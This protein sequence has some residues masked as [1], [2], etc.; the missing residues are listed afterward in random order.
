M[1]E[2]LTLPYS[3]V[4]DGQYQVGG[5]WEGWPL[6]G[7]I[8]QVYAQ[9]SVT[10]SIHSGVDIDGGAEGVAD[11]WFPQDGIARPQYW[12]DY[13][14]WYSVEIEEPDP[15]YG[16]LF[17]CLA[18][19]HPGTL[20]ITSPTRITAGTFA[21]KM[22]NSGK[23]FGAH[24]HFSVSYDMYISGDY[25]RCVDP[26]IFVQRWHQEEE[27]IPE[28]LQGFMLIAE[29]DPKVMQDV[30]FAL[31]NFRGQGAS[32]ALYPVG[33]FHEINT[34]DGTVDPID[35][36]ATDLNDSVVM[37][38]RIRNLAWRMDAR[39]RDAWAIVK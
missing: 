9:P 5:I 32:G 14:Y 27:M 2:L 24:T 4:R 15:I 34:S 6:E 37:S 38:K 18:H 21:G 19:L 23:S 8:T 22:G 12:G 31:D 33:F 7:V 28:Y 10:S 17:Y 13:G 1:T 30:Y 16:K 39:S 26:Y 20:A 11:V 35:G 3:D 36:D 29:G 25:R